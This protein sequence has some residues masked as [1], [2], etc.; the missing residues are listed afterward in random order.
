M[1]ISTEPAH[2]REFLL[3]D[4]GT[5]SRESVA[6][7]KGVKLPAG[8]V[9]GRRADDGRV[10]GWHPSATDGTAMAV[11]IIAHPV[12]GKAAH[13]LAFVRGCTVKAERLGWPAGITDEQKAVAVA[14]L[15][16][17]GIIAR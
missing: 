13:G 1:P 6:L 10:I 11:G 9:L 3:S 8:A 7:V 5:R 14:Q 15:A 16:A 12:D 2:A 17:V 4:Y